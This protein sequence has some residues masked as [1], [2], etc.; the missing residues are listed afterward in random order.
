MDSVAW[1]ALGQRS[2][3]VV[4]NDPLPDL[5]EDVVLPWTGEGRAVVVFDGEGA[6]LPV[7]AWADHGTLEG[8]LH[9]D[10]H[11]ANAQLDEFL[12]WLST[13]EV[14]AGFTAKRHLAYLAGLGRDEMWEA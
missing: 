2:F 12:R 5:G 9:P 4:R 1:K 7:V 6:F 11:E 3:R 13:A 10:F 8:D 14:M